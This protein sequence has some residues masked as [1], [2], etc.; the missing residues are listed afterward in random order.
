MINY[1][2]IPKEKSLMNFGVRLY[3]P[4]DVDMDQWGVISESPD[5]THHPDKILSP[6]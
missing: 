2:V 4:G 3:T 1:I 6:I 5:G